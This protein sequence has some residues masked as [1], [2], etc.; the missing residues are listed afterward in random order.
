MEACVWRLDAWSTTS[1]LLDFAGLLAVLFPLGAGHCLPAG[2][3]YTRC[4]GAHA[5]P[6]APCRRIYV[7]AFV[8]RALVDCVCFSL[9][10]KNLFA[11]ESLMLYSWCCSLVYIDK[12]PVTA[13]RTPYR[14]RY[15]K[16]LDRELWQLQVR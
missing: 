12:Q 8:W 5:R 1:P 9:R 15:W 3:A 11:F 14:C 10:G 6:S 13:S 4:A 7:T 2:L 16:S